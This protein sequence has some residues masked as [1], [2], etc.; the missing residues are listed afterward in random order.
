M[1]YIQLSEKVKSEIASYGQLIAKLGLLNDIGLIIDEFKKD[2]EDRSFAA[3]YYHATLS[4][5]GSSITAEVASADQSLEVL[6]W[7]RTRGW[8]SKKFT[9]SSE[10]QTRSYTLAHENSINEITLDAYF[11][12]G[13]CEFVPVKGKRKHI[14]GTEAIPAQKGKYVPVMELKC[15]GVALPTE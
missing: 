4:S 10:S 8:K 1:S 5:Y 11:S 2:S 7:F 6:E 14:K 13:T 3:S 9:D 12:G 15:D